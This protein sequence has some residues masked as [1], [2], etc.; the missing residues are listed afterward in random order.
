[1]AIQLYR[2]WLAHTDSHI[3]YAVQFNLGVALSN[4]NDTI[5]AEAAYRAVIEQNP[6]FL[7]AYL[8]LGSLLER[9][10]RPEEALNMW[11]ATLS[12]IKLESPRDCALYVQALNNLGRLLEIR[13]ELSEA[14]IMLKR[15]LKQNPTQSDVM[16]YL[17]QL[18]Q[19]QNTQGLKPGDMGAGQPAMST[20]ADSVSISVIIPTCNRP[21][22]LARSLRS[23][24]AQTQLPR[25]IIIVNDAGS[26]VEEVIAQYDTNGIVH[27]EVHATNR[28]ASAAR[29]TG[30]HLAQGDYIAFLD[31][32][33]M[34]LPDHLA[35]MIE[36]LQA[37]SCR[38]GYALAEYVI[39]DMRDGKSVCVGRCQPFNGITYS[40]D[41]LLVANF[42][43]TP[44]WV[45]SRSLLEDIGYF[46]E[47]FA[48]CEDWEWLIRASE[49]TD[50]L[51]VK[52]VTV[53][54]HQRL[55]DQQH[56]ILQQGSK[57]NMW[58][59]AVYA[60]HPVSLPLQL[61]RYEYITYGP[62]KPLSAELAEVVDTAFESARLGSL[63]LS[64]LFKAAEILDS[65]NLRHRSIQLY[66]Q[67]LE[68]SQSPQRF[69]AFFNLGVV[70]QNMSQYADA[71]QAYREAISLK[72][73]FNLTHLQL[74]ELLERRGCIDEAQENW[75]TIVR[76]EDNKD[77]LESRQASAHL[78]RVSMASL[79]A[80]GSTHP[81]QP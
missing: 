37:N 60:K 21:D 17:I 31:D 8:N 81:N 15:S 6:A 23:V 54:V 35:T 66:Q 5:G 39:N 57:L 64:G 52:A 71:E 79:K 18:R 70:L 44:T 76:Q 59:Q 48:A 11:R 74:A 75:R 16:A 47:F 7:E 24:L 43:P 65:A 2:I 4:T 51:T 9:T 63:D 38:F 42:I 56:L 72:P 40:R 13:G 25:E 29:N 3:A 80:A 73:D 28:G 14:E 30:L 78:D 67:W 12:F 49:K 19:K 1:M 58:I 77:T 46:D 32:D 55:Y 68:H 34:Y 33:D 53:E 36:A 45:F 22:M 61:E 27:C 69:A 62:A 20:K 41:R 26:S 10:G 50:F